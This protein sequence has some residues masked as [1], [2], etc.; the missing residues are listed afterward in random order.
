MA[1]VTKVSDVMK[2]NK[3]EFIEEDRVDDVDRFNK[4]LT[5]DVKSHQ[6]ATASNS[7]NCWFYKSLILW[8]TFKVHI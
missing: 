5:K 8:K 2:A 3:D 1:F 4:I 6:N 7:S